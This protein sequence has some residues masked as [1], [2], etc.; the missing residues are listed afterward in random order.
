MILDYIQALVPKRRGM[1]FTEAIDEAIGEY[2]EFALRVNVPVIALCQLSRDASKPDP[3][4]QFRRPQ[5]QDLSDSKSI[6]QWASAVLLLY[7][8]EYYKA[9]HDGREESRSSQAEIL[10]PKNRYGAMGRELCVW[11]SWRAMYTEVGA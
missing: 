5:M 7:R 4:G 9:R 2:K 6:E 3:K 10:I 8:E 11:D 1:S